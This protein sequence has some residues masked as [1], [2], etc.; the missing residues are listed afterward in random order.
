MPSGGG[1]NALI[2]STVLATESRLAEALRNYADVLFARGE[3]N[4]TASSHIEQAEMESAH[5]VRT[6]LKTT[7]QP[8]DHIALVSIL[9]TYFTRLR[10]SSIFLTYIID[11]CC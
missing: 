9:L 11:L 6:A 10:I 4:E 3:G 2:T 7:V 1:Y 5:K 8:L